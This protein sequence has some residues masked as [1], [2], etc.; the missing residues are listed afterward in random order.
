VAQAARQIFDA[1]PADSD[2][3]QN[4]A[5]RLQLEGIA[6]EIDAGFT[7]EQMPADLIELRVRIIEVLGQSS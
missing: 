4:R 1:R 7:P 6:R 3:D 5:W 2:E